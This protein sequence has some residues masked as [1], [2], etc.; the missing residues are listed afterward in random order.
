[1]FMPPHSRTTISQSAPTLAAPCPVSSALSTDLAGRCH[2]LPNHQMSCAI[3]W[4]TILVLIVVLSHRVLYTRLLPLCQSARASRDQRL[5][6]PA[7]SVM[8]SRLHT[9]VLLYSPVLLKICAVLRSPHAA[10][11][12]LR[13]RAFS[14]GRRISS[15][16]LPL[17]RSR[18]CA[19]QPMQSSTLNPGELPRAMRL[20]CK[21]CTVSVHP[22]RCR[23][24]WVVCTHATARSCLQSLV[25]RLPD[26]ALY[27][28]TCSLLFTSCTWNPHLKLSG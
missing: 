27:R 22:C 10:C 20:A 26:L 28:H 21:A 3:S 12:A 4:L 9:P 13:G 2:P 5:S 18:M 17:H 7:W 16:T 23:S 25:C 11:R 19:L 14:A 8:R 6:A 1:M 24:A 15:P